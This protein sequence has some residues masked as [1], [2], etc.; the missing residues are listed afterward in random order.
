[1]IQTLAVLFIIYEITKM[2]F[3][4]KYIKLLMD[5]G[6]IKALDSKMINSQDIKKMLISKYSAVFLIEMIYLI[7]VASLLFTAYWFVGLL[8]IA[9]ALIYKKRLN[10]KS[11]ISDSLI[12]IIVLM[13]IFIV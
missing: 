12:S 10:N 7:F 11:M 5:M 4:E 6:N 2:L 9:L 8:L 1:M 3:P 13:L